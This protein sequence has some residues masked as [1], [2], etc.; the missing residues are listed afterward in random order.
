MTGYTQATGMPRYTIQIR[1]ADA[2]TPE[3]GWTGQA[4]DEQSARQLA[5]ADYRCTHPEIEA[6]AITRVDRPSATPP[7]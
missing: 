4:S 7:T 1:P 5:E 6:L 2:Q 3:M